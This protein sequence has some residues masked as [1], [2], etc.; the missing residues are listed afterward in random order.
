MGAPLEYD[1][2]VVG[3]AA[4]ERE[5]AALERRFI[6][7]ANKL[8]STF[9]KLGGGTGGGSSGGRAGTGRIGPMFG[10]GPREQMAQIRA[11][12]RA[13]IA[14]TRAKAKAE[15]DAAREAAKSATAQ[16]RAIDQ[17][18]KTQTALARQRTREERAAATE[19]RRITSARVD[20]ARSTVGAGV[21][22]VAGAIGSVGRV[23]AAVA[24]IGAAGLAASAIAQATQLDEMTR[25]LAIAGRGKGEKGLSSAD[26]TRQFT[27]TGIASG[28]SPEQIASGAAAYVAKTGDLGTALKNQ[29][30]FATVAQ[31]AGA[32]V[33]EVFSAA[34]DMAQKMDITSVKD[35]SEAF[36]ILSTQGKK[37]SFELK[38]MAA[39]FPSV[40]SSAANA[41]AKGI[42]GIRDVGATM[43]LAMQST[44]NAAEASTAVNAMFRQIQAKGR[45]MQSGKSF[46]G[47]KVNVW[48]GGDPTKKMFG[49]ADIVA[50]AI[51]ASRG[52]VS[53]LNEVFDAR[54]VK[55]I[56]PMIA[57]YRE[58]N[59]NAG[60]GKAGDEA[61]KIAVKNKF[62]EFR[63][64]SGDFGEIE[65]DAQDAMKSFSVQMEIINTKLKDAIGSQL[66]P[67]I[68]KLI[69]QITALVPQVAKLVSGFVK[70]VSWLADNPLKGI[71][72]ALVASIG[73]EMAK[74]RLGSVLADGLKAILTGAQT[75]GFRGAAGAVLPT[76]GG[77]TVA[78][79]MGAAGTGLAIGAAVAGTIYGGGV[80]K[81]ESGENS[82]A[83]GG[84][85]LNTVRGANTSDIE[86]VRQIIAEQK[87]RVSET[88]KTDVLDDV[89]GTFGASNKDVEVKTQES[90]LAEMQKTLS[91]LEMKAAA[92]QQKAAAEALK[93]AASD[94]SNAKPNRSDKPTGIK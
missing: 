8:N 3:R 1:F 34:A 40:F 44:G 48:E 73:L 66:F 83:V 69:P 29:G 11:N 75:G 6:S 60:G 31:G 4:V 82:M 70:L 81:F 90:F 77:T 89:L 56:N 30:T 68:V 67:E 2:R 24:G 25:R 50:N 7:S 49:F 52:D 38:A 59:L 5:I 74:A 87:K 39:E 88:K 94:L 84:A 57:A 17:R 47:R 43:Q 26:L 85:A 63:D 9:N 19:Q 35:M 53:Q 16:Q 36:A 61:G 42:S 45:E 65:R 58:A 10:P 33:T 86:A 78:G 54:G 13:A 32:D 27:R 46:S 28:F 64:V 41:G 72:I 18:V 22:R 71:G 20:F 23:G 51:S 93:A 14:A 91:G 55:A 15:R 21:G 37:G 12:E 92:E 62:S 76:R 79:A 80:A